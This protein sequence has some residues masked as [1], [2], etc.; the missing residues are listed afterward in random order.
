MNLFTFNQQANIAETEVSGDWA[1][2]RGSWTSTLTPK[3]EGAA[4]LIDGKFMTILR[5]QADGS[6]KLY[7]DIFNSNTE[8]FVTPIGD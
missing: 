5:R 4:F 6:W 8:T 1:F 2:S 7:R 3:G